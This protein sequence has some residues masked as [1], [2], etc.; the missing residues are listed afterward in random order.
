MGFSYNKKGYLRIKVFSNVTLRLRVRVFRR[1]E[2]KYFSK[3][4]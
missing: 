2:G 4:R 1:F 3:R